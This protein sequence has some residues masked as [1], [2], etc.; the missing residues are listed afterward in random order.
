MLV[1]V[2]MPGM[3]G[4]ELLERMLRRE[5]VLPVILM[6]GHGDVPMAVRALKAG[7]FD[8]IEKP[9]NDQMLLDRL[10]EAIEHGEA[11]R[12]LEGER[13]R[14]V[15]AYALLTPREREV[16]AAIVAG[17]L[18]K[19][20][21]DDLDVSVRTVEIHRAHITEK[22]GAKSLAALVRMGLLLEGRQGV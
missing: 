14:A 16:M 3:S 13:R 22:M 15:A 11:S 20:I 17:R 1:D 5:V 18:N 2:R 7:A 8:F 9:F 4:L 6:T 19:L 10:A 21:A 12:D